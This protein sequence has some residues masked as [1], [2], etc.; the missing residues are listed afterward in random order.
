M[1]HVLLLAMLALFF[2]EVLL[3]WLFGH[4]SAVPT[5][6]EEAARAQRH[7]PAL[8]ADPAAAVRRGRLAVRVPDRRRRRAGRRT[9]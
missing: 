5:L 8:A 9:P 2:C 1:A 6:E 7:A 3:A 4:Y